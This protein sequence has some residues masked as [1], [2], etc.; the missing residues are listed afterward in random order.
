MISLSW[1]VKTYFNYLINRKDEYSL[2]SPFAF[3]LYNYLKKDYS[4]KNLELIN[5]IRN[6]Q[7]QNKTAIDVY[8]LGAGSQTI[9]SHKVS[10]I[11]TYAAIPSKYGKLLYRLVQKFKPETV[12]ELGTSTGI[13][14]LYLALAN[15]SRVVS[16]EGNKS[17]SSVAKDNFIKAGCTNIE[18]LT[19]EFSSQLPVAINK[20]QK[21]DFAFID[22]NHQYQ[23]T[24]DYF[25]LIKNNSEENSI[26]IFDDI[27]WSQGMTQAWEKIKVDKVVKVSMDFYR[28]GIVF[29]KK[30]LKKQHYILKI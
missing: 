8:D 12:L 19:G 30:E 16:I 17:I 3:E 14:T 28:L 10:E 25:N 23:P 22:G 26:F 2:H 29:L 6:A 9:T 1:K 4:D 18:I 27:Y 15:D 20:L 24:I 11:T 7:L 5:S 21:I 13:S